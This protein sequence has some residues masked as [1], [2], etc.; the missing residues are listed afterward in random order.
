MFVCWSRLVAVLAVAVVGPGSMFVVRIALMVCVSVAV[1]AVCAIAV[2]GSG[3]MF[4]VR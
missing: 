1:L 4:V 2:V 3:S